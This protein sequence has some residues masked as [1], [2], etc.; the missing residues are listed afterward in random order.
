MIEVGL[1]IY[2]AGFAATLIALDV[3]NR[4]AGW[5]KTWQII[6][7]AL[8]WPVTVPL[9]GWFAYRMARAG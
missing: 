1:I 2:L 9:G 4:A 7:G 3:Q 5:L 6:W 8:V